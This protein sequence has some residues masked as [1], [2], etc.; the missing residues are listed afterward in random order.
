MDNKK[1]DVQQAILLIQNIIANNQGDI[2]R[3]NFII[4]SLKNKKRLYKSDQNYIE[5]K[6]NGTLSY[7]KLEQKNKNFDL[8]KQIKFLINN[9]QGDPGRLHYILETI[10]KEKNLFKT[11]QT[12]L[13]NKLKIIKQKKVIENKQ[14]YPEEN[15]TYKIITQENTKRSFE[16][17]VEIQKL[18]QELEISK[19]S[20]DELKEKLN[21]AI[22]KI[23]NLQKI[24]EDKNL[25]I[26]TKNQKI[27][28]LRQEISKIKLVSN[29]P[30]LKEITN[31]IN[32]E[33]EKISNQDILHDKIKQHKEKLNQ[34]IKYRKEYEEKILKAKEDINK[35]LLSENKKIRAHDKLVEE[36]VHSQK[37]LEQSKVE[38][39]I[40][41]EQIKKE[42]TRLLRDM[43][44]QQKSLDESKAEFDKTLSDPKKD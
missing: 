34:L 27:D 31:Q 30:E 4:E 16:E 1:I 10:K 40:I 12:Y 11:D 22:N 32:S 23:S 3:L 26:V 9:K 38:Q 18:K 39:E 8:Q 19:N 43:S 28:T 5:K 33:N 17:Q 15:S 20:N 14:I 44:D 41:L 37:Q 7:K 25:E 21:D 35:Q 24:I 13:E 36:L 29:N 6:I 2:G 42:Q